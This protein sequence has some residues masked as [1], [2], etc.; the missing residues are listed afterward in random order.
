[1]T[2]A[3]QLP[4]LFLKK[5][6]LIRVI[7]CPPFT[8]YLLP[9]NPTA[10]SLR[11]AGSAAAHMEV[12]HHQHTHHKKWTQYIWDFFMLFLA[13]TMGFVVENSREHYVEHRRMKKYLSHVLADVKS[14]ITQID[15]LLKENKGILIRYDSMLGELLK[16]PAQ[17]DRYSYAQRIFPVFM[18]LFKNRKE[19]FEQMIMTGSLRY[20]DNDAVLN[21]L[22]GYNR[23]ADLAEWRAMENE[24]KIALEQNYPEIYRHFDAT[25][26]MLDIPGN[27]PQ[28]GHRD[29]ITGKSA[30]DFCDQVSKA[31]VSRIRFMRLSYETYQQLKIQSQGFASLL[32][33]YLD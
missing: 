33:D 15:S 30:E 4:L 23:F 25:C 7:V 18:R 19:T 3:L 10:L 28:P 6:R 17:L 27:L 13:I 12:Q 29:I 20:L 2:P 16:K 24:R 31:F 26:L 22:V 8:A 32:E 5:Y 14:N 11:Q 21:G 9:L 1:M